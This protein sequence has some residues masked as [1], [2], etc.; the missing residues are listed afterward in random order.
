MTVNGKSDRGQ[1]HLGDSVT[2]SA[3]RVDGEHAQGGD[4]SP[5]EVCT[6]AQDLW[7]T[8]SPPTP[9]YRAP[10]STTANSVIA[11]INDR[12]PGL[13]PAKQHLLL[14]FAQGHH[15]GRT[16]QPLFADDLHA[17]DRSVTVNTT[18]EASP[19]TDEGLLSTVTTA[20]VRYSSLSPADLRTLVQASTPWQKARSN[21]GD[22]RIDPAWLTEWFRRPDETD[23]PDDERPNSAERAEAEAYLAAKGT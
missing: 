13:K 20:V 3:A 15:L 12:R 9:T 6:E 7:A 19:I 18:G 2:V 23:D 8:A 17:T 10:M 22:T 1:S 16:G 4:V 14:F 5:S 21:N 11:A